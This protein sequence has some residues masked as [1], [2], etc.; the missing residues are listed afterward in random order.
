MQYRRPPRRFTAEALENMR[1]RYEETDEPQQSIANDYNICR[2]TLDRRAKDEGWTLRK[3]RLPHDVPAALRIEAEA[4]QAVRAEEEARLTSAFR[5]RTEPGGV[6]PEP[7]M[8]TEPQTPEG[9]SEALSVAERFER[10]VEKELAVVEAKRA[11]LGPRA[12]STADGERTARTLASLTAT[13][14]KIRLLRWPDAGIA[15]APVPESYDDDFPADIDE[16]RHALARRI[17]AFV[18]SRIGGAIPATGDASGGDP[19][20][21]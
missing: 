19:P 5:V 4:E 6:G 13:L 9:T 17:E 1:F 11:L 2:K 18:R 20:E 10:A 12:E 7:P 15:S 21:P 8:P 3:N 16:F 14:H